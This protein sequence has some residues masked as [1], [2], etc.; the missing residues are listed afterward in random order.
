MMNFDAMHPGYNLLLPPHSS[1]V[2]L[3]FRQAKME[4]EF[5]VVYPLVG[6]WSGIRRRNVVSFD[7]NVSKPS[8]SLMWKGMLF[9]NFGPITAKDAS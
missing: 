4:F 2:L 8:S 9:H 7:L 1:V 5:V 6:G 3:L